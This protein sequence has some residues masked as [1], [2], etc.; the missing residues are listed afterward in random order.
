MKE[1]WIDRYR[2]LYTQ[3]KRANHLTN[4]PLSTI[5]LG[6]NDAKSFCQIYGNPKKD[7]EIVILSKKKYLIGFKV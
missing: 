2:R 1:I 4:E 7:Y 3:F 5:I 6:T